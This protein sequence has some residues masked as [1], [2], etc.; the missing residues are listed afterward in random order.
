MDSDPIVGEIRAIRERIAA[1]FNYDIDAIVDDAQQR[2][3]TCG[4]EIIRRP[5]CRPD[6]W[7]EPAA[8]SAARD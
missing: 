2:E 3:A 5:P 4:W 7:Q 8:E 1:R 6:G